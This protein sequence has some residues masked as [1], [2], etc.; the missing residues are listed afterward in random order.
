MTDRRTIDFTASALGAVGVSVAP[1]DT[2]AVPGPSTGSGI[3]GQS[4]TFS[5]RVSNTDTELVRSGLVAFVDG[6]TYL[7]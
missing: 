2:A 7:R 5:H 6:A 1:A 4:V 3:H